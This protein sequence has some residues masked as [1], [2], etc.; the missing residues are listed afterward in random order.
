[1]SNESVSEKERAVVK[2][3]E[4]CAQTDSQIHSLMH[5][6]TH[7]NSF[8]HS[9]THSFTCSLSDRLTNRESEWVSVLK[10]GQTSPAHGA[11]GAHLEYKRHV[12][13]QKVAS[14]TPV[15][16]EPRNPGLSPRS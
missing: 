7:T 3:G 6:P 15:T 16:E 1:M 14:C 12:L 10:T 11:V 13:L 4:K 9:V 8:T 2:N 5:S